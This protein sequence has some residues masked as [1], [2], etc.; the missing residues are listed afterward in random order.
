MLERLIYALTRFAIWLRRVPLLRFLIEAVARRL[1]ARKGT[2]K[3][4][5]GAGLRFDA[6]GGVP[7]YLFGTYELDGQQLLAKLLKPGHTLYD[8]GGN[9]G[10]YTTIG[11]HLVGPEG[12]VYAFEPFPSSAQ[13]IRKNAALNG[14]TNVSVYEVAALD[15]GGTIDLRVRSFS[16]WNEIVDPDNVA[17]SD[18][19]HIIKVPTVAIDELVEA[20]QLKPPDLVKIDVQG[21]EISVLRGMMKTIR[22]NRPIIMCEVHRAVVNAF[23]DFVDQVIRPL[24][25][26]VTT[27]LGEAIPDEAEPFDALLVPKQ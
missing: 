10:F 17:N 7:D 3:L 11:A 15:H 21:A 19:G 1:S 2:I 22:S 16:S 12:Q 8:I 24:G 18:E 6:T 13:A 20:D 5:I 14:F 27:Y 26:E 25:Y 4:G 9:I 23:S